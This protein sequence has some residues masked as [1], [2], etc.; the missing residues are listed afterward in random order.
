MWF[1]EIPG[2]QTEQFA[3]QPLKGIQFHV[4]RKH[5]SRTDTGQSECPPPCGHR[6]PQM[7]LKQMALKAGKEFSILPSILHPVPVWSRQRE[8]KAQRLQRGGLQP[9]PKNPS[10]TE[11]NFLFWGWELSLKTC[12]QPETGEQSQS[13]NKLQWA[14]AQDFP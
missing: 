10:Q 1:W 8:P 11:T 12:L 4:Y 6:A 9:P 7:L 14:L 2:S 5:C 3:K 13:W